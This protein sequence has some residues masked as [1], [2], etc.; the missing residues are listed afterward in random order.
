LEAFPENANKALKV[1]DIVTTMG[2]EALLSEVGATSHAVDW[3]HR[4]TVRGNK[5]M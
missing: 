1:T 2:A 4:C 5:A 3:Q